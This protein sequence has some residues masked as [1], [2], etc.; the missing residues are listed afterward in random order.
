MEL[1][2]AVIC[3]QAAERPDGKLDLIGV[4]NELSA[5]GF[6][7]LQER[8]TVVFVM[9]WSPE[10]AGR[11]PLRADLIDEDERR[12]LTIEGHTDVSARR[13]GNGRAQ[14][15]LILPLERIV[16][17]RAGHYYF[18]LIAGGDVRRACSLFVGSTESA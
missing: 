9:E 10:E 5:P 11:Q 8:M 16:F 1:I 17:P 6:P 7:A 12:V 4:F 15:R 3:D 18:D 14:T 13:G 2:L